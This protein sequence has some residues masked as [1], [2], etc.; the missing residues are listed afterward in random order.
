M[1]SISVPVWQ[2]GTPQSMQRAPCW[3]SVSSSAVLME[4]EPIADR[5]QPATGLAAT[6]AD[7]P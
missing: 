2:N 1:P 7:I 6:R 3:R 5:A 4:L